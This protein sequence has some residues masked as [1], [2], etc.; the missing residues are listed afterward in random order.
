MI[1][2]LLWD[3]VYILGERTKKEEESYKRLAHVTVKVKC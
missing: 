2:L 1:T 3:N